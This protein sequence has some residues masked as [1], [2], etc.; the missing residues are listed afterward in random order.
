MFDALAVGIG[1]AATSI[2][3]G[4]QDIYDIAQANPIQNITY[5]P[6]VIEVPFQQV[7]TYKDQYTE[8]VAQAPSGSGMQD[9]YGYGYSPPAAHAFII[10]GPTGRTGGLF[11]S[12]TIGGEA[13]PEWFV[14]T[15][16]PERSN[17]LRDVGA[18]PETI[19][20]TI[21]K[22]L[23]P[24]MSGSDGQTF[25]LVVDG[26]VIGNIVA[27]ETGTNPALRNAIQRIS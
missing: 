9:V 21:A 15:Y 3:G 22:K 27:K 18:D 25:V 13:G 12:P 20:T 24:L 8:Y 16:E 7:G 6:V 10:W 1:Q 5:E 19:G 17:F 11:G 14:P 26:E 23:A 4:I 2:A